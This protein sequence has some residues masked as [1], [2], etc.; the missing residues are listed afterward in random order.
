VVTIRVGCRLCRRA[1][2]L[3]DNGD[4]IGR[5]KKL[6]FAKCSDMVMRMLNPRVDCITTPST[7]EIADTRS[8]F[9]RSEAMG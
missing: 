6:N 2:Q 4:A 3:K 5:K 7:S 8:G 1:G 9:G